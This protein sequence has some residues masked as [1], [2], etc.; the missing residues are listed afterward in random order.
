M[1]TFDVEGTT[2]HCQQLEA[3][4]IW[5]CSCDYF[6][7]RHRR[8]AARGT[9]GYCPH[10]AVAIMRAIQEGTVDPR[11]EAASEFEVFVERAGGK[12]W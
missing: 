5:S 9:G 12:L 2:V 1:R 4:R 11:D 10:I 8:P 6:R 3:K 7:E